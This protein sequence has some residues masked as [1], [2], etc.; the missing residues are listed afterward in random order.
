MTAAISLPEDNLKTAVPLL[1]LCRD[2]EIILE[3]ETGVVGGEEDGLNR[4]GIDKE[5]LYTTPEDM[6]A[7]HE[8]LSPVSGSRFMLAAT[9][10]NVHGV[11]KPGNVVLTPTILKDGQEAVMA[12]HGD[13]ARFWLVFHG[14]IWLITGRNS[15]DVGLWR[16]QNERRH[17][18]AV[19][20]HPPGG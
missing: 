9:F 6:L 2:N 4:E 13:D 1:E 8:A 16:N 11:Y 17:G 5:K 20:I 7:V 3:V 18:Y 14:W 12:K 19:C 15:R 10:G